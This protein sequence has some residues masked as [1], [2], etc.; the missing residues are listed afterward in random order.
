[1]LVRKQHRHLE[2]SGQ[3]TEWIIVLPLLARVVI[4]HL[5]FLQR[6][7]QAL[8]AMRA[9]VLRAKHSWETYVSVIDPNHGSQYADV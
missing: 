5:T 7:I 8:G 2:S 3:M 4:P 1:M 9:P 6:G